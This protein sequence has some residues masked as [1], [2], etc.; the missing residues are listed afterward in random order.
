M[1]PVGSRAQE[2]LWIVP[3]VLVSLLGLESHEK[4]AL[5][6][7]SNNVIII[8]VPTSLEL[9]LYILY[10]FYAKI[11]MCAVLTCPR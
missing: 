7:Y 4:E 10:S 11:P 8:G 5:L 1:W 2:G 3:V 6:L 9:R